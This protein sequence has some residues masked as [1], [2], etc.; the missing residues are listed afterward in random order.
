MSHP[1]Q[2]EFIESIKHHL[3]QYFSGGAVLEIGSLDINGS[4]RNFFEH[5][6]YVGVDVADGPGVDKVCQGQL[7]DYPSESLDVV[8]S[9]ECMEHNPYWVETISNMLRMAK[10]GGLVVMSCASTGRAEHGTSRTSKNDSPLTVGMG[11]EYYRNLNA[12]DIKNSFNLD[13]WFSDYIMLSNWQSCDLYLVGLKKLDAADLS[14]FRTLKAAL[15]R[16]YRVLR[17]VRTAVVFVTASLFREPG[18]AAL[19][20][21]YGIAARL[22]FVKKK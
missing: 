1:E 4:V 6:Q 11:W 8:I 16:K 9:C 19:H 17:S 12:R 18:V 14:A 3:P 2:L 22:G 7:V 21:V 5:S 15:S 13:Q 20:A 10:A